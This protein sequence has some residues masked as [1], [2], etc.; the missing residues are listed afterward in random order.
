MTYEKKREKMNRPISISADDEF[1]FQN[2]DPIFNSNSEQYKKSFSFHENFGE[3]T[4]NDLQGNDGSMCT[5]NGNSKFSIQVRL[6][7]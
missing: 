2:E 1:D 4:T 7:F 3:V 5:A 6:V